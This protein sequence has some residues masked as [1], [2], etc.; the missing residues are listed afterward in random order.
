MVPGRLIL[1][2]VLAFL[3]TAA[4][5]AERQEPE[6]GDNAEPAERARW[7]RFSERCASD[8]LKTTSGPEADFEDDGRA[9]FSVSDF[10]TADVSGLPTATPALAEQ[11]ED[12]RGADR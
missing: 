3:V 5:S 1:I 7:Q 2:S 9:G 6:T 10:W 4:A 11:A 8:S 12:W